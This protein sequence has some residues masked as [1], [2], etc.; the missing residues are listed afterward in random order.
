MMP[1]AM[2]FTGGE[3]GRAALSDDPAWLRELDLN[4]RPPAYEADE[5]TR[6]L[7]PAIKIFD[8]FGIQGR[9]AGPTHLFFY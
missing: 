6:L 3:Q 9:S 8:L 2:G 1:Y 5:R 7:H 4:Q